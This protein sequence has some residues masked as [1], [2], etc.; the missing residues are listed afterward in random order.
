MAERRYRED[1]SMPL[2]PG[3]II[4]G[5]Y[6]V[7]RCIGE[8]GMG[9]VF[10]G[11]NTR[12]GR[13][14]AIKVLHAHVASLPEF[15]ERFEKEA[16]AAARIG[17]S[18]V[19]DVFDLGDLPGGDRYIVM[20]YLDGISLEARMEDKVRMTPQEIAPIAFELL[21]GLSTMHGAGV[22]HRDLKPA[23]VFLTRTQSGR[24][25]EVRIL[26]F[27]VAKI[28]PFPGEVASMTQTGAM[29]G[30]PLYMSPEQ[31]RGAKDVD[32]RSDIYS[33][34]VM[35]YRALTGQLP[36]A[37][38]SLNELLFKIVLEEPPPILSVV[39]DVDEA[40]AAIIQRGMVRDPELR[41]PTARAYQ[42]LIAAWGRAQ[43]RSSMHFSV[44]NSER[45]GV[46]ASASFAPT[47]TGPQIIPAEVE[48]F[49]RAANQTPAGAAGAAGPRTG[50]G[51]GNGT[52][53]GT[54]VVGTPVVWSGDQGNHAQTQQPVV[55]STSPAAVSP[56]KK[57]IMPV[58]AVAASL[59]AVVGIVAV[60]M[61]KRAEKPLTADTTS[62]PSAQTVATTPPSEPT[63]LSAP[64]TLPPGQTGQPVET[65]ASTATT[66][67]AVA[68]PTPVTARRP[69]DPAKPKTSADLVAQPAPIQPPAVP[70][71]AAS[72]QHGRKYRTNID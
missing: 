14:V 49:A 11:E 17:S 72:V 1:L 36:F 4:E 59:F 51:N 19:C 15:V 28:Q 67:T 16:R 57:P 39:P 63:S 58:L 45:G 48:A 62:S 52:G 32:A 21:D 41:I 33:V 7:L 55:A 50:I 69:A 71:A 29:M 5:K 31:A 66:Q 23:N 10:E 42:E 65:T 13:R 47:Y 22:I 53:T 20:E 60:V 40:F 35:F 2:A 54:A 26:D 61:T 25:E 9:A 38:T 46:A 37:A 8:G 43:G 6:R 34:S 70:S 18:Y 44:P 68:D 3:Q 30:T 24:G 56:R 27:G 12:I 64:P